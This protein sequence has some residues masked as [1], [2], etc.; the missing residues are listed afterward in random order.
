M[1]DYPELA[2]GQLVPQTILQQS[3]GRAGAHLKVYRG[4][5]LVPP[6]R[7]HLGDFSQ[8]DEGV[9]VFAGQ[10]TRIGRHVHLA[11]DTAIFGGGECEIGDYA[12]TS[13]G[14]RIITGSDLVRG[15]GL[16]NPTI[17]AH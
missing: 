13:A 6:E 11:F 8:I 9:R 12:S 5:R 15:G 14:V 17:P 16:V 4:C 7:I 10:G 3:L 1:M 2:P